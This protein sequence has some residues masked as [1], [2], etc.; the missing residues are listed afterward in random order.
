MINIL[1]AE[2]QTLVRQGLK[3]MLETDEEVSVTAEAENGRE[4]IDFCIHSRFDLILL[5]IRMPIM[6]GLEA[7]KII[8]E[9]W[10]ETPILMLTTFN[11]EEYALEAFKNKANGYLLKD[12]NASELIKS[13]KS[14]VKGGLAIEDQVAAK[15]L[16]TLLENHTKPSTIDLGLTSREIE[17]IKAIG[18][19]KNNQE[20]A[21]TLFLSVGTV[22]NH[23]S[24]VLTK[25]SLRDRTQIAIYAVRHH[26]S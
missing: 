23:I 13:V 15:V 20:I 2:D 8:R 5:D 18:E 14:I 6:N 7:G 24:T 9:R 19:G 12:G 22:K 17:I 1:I 3:M 16:P 21:E 25:L 4:A 11:D 26:L 10:P